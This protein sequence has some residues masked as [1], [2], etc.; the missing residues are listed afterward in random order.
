MPS[1][2]NER[3]EISRPLVGILT[4]ACF[5][6]AAVVFW[7][8]PDE[9][10]WLSGFIRVGLLMSAFWLALPTRSRPAAWSRVSPLTFVLLLLGLVILP[11][12]PRY[13]IPI[14]LVV[15]VAALILRPRNRRAIE[16]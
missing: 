14:G 7:R 3:I 12:Y 4:V 15:A 6:G 1:M 9:E 2:G 10:L 16:R 13:I 5:V 8:Y 11:R